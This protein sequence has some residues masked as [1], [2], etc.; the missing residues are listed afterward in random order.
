M[1]RKYYNIIG[2]RKDSNIET[3]FDFSTNKGKAEFWKRQ[4]E[5][6]PGYHHWVFKIVEHDF[7]MIPP[8][9]DDY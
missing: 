9:N 3:L 4:L 5:I 2:T 1:K 8:G 7:P 6:D